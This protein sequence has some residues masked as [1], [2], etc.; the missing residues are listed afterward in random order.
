MKRFLSCFRIAL[1]TFTIGIIVCAGWNFISNSQMPAFYSETNTRFIVKPVT[2]KE[3]VLF[4]Y[5]EY[6]DKHC[7]RRNWN[8]EQEKQL[9]ERLN[10]I[11][12]LNQK[13]RNSRK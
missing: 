1:L 7:P 2:S 12:R 10:K 6:L 8:P 11:E 5:S 3:T 13:S 9:V 4:S